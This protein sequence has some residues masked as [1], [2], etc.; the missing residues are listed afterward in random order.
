M[1]LLSQ[2]N[3]SMSIQIFEAQEKLKSLTSMVE[4]LFDFAKELVHP[5]YKKFNARSSIE[6]FSSLE[7]DSNIEK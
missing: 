3:D 2:E 1:S 4:K 5:I 7:T 6:L